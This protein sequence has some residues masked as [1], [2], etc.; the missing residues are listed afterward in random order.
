MP[1]GLAGVGLCTSEQ[2]ALM[3]AGDAIQQFDYVARVSIGVIERDQ[4]QR[5]CN[6]GA[7]QMGAFGQAGRAIRRTRR[8]A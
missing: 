1:D 8:R 3:R 5:P 7:L 6:C 4:Q 2:S